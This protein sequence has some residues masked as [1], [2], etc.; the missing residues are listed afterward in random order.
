MG[1]GGGGGGGRKRAEVG[2]GPKA[3]SRGRNPHVE[4]IH[5]KLIVSL[6]IQLCASLHSDNAKHMTI[7]ELREKA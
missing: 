4:S 7:H 3:W 1:G 6:V 5:R 2:S